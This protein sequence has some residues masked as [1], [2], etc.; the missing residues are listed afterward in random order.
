MVIDCGLRIQEI[1]PIKG[2]LGDG[3]GWVEIDGQFEQTGHLEP[4]YWR[5]LVAYDGKK[6][7]WKVV[8]K[9][10]T[11]SY[12]DLELRLDSSINYLSDAVLQ[13]LRERCLKT[14]K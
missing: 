1:S 4:S 14:L 10:E 7:Y 9:T 3:I 13:E 8:S 2:Y 12:I 5:A 6:L 11:T